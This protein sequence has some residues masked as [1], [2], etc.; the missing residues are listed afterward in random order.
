MFLK[1]VNKKGFLRS[2]LKEIIHEK[3]G[4]KLHATLP[5]KILVDADEACLAFTPDKCAPID[6]VLLDLGY[7]FCL[8]IKR[9]IKPC[10]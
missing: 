1:I 9:R 7:G 4:I 6:E 3:P 8:Q 10:Y 5:G 2:Q